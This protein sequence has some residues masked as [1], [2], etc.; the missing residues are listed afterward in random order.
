MIPIVARGPAD[1]RH[2]ELLAEA[3][4][5]R[6]I[7]ALPAGPGTLQRFALRRAGGG[8]RP[9]V[10]PGPAALLPRPYRPSAI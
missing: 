10:A 8:Q 2:Q 7:A 6:L 9:T 4:R 1:G 3:E 5:R